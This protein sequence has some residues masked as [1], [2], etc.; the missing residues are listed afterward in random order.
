VNAGRH[1]THAQQSAFDAPYRLCVLWGGNGIGK[2]LTLAELARRHLGME[3]PWQRSGQ[4]PVVVLGGNTWSQLGSTLHYLWDSLPPGWL[5]PGVR[6]ESGGLK[7]QRLQVYDI[8]GGPGA[9][10]ELRC[11]T[12]SAGAQ[13]LA[14][15]RASYVLCDE[16]VKESI[17]NE[18]W[19]RLFGR[20]GRMVQTFTVTMST[21]DDLGYLWALVDDP[22]KPWAG[23]IQT[24]LTLDAVTPRGGVFEY[25]WMSA[26]EI[27]Q[28]EAGLS[29]VEA[30]MRMG[31]TRTPR[32]N[33]AWFSSWGPHLIHPVHPPGGTPLGVG[34]DH[35]SRPGAQRA[36]LVAVGGRGPRARAWILG[37]H[38]GDGRTESE[39]DARGILAML[40]RAGVALADV[41]LWVGDRAHGGDSRGGVKS[42]ARLLRSFALALGIDTD[43]REWTAKLPRNLRN[44]RTPRKYNRSV[45]EGMEVL[46]R[47]TVG[48]D[49][50]LT[51][52]PDPCCAPLNEDFAL[53][54]GGQTDPHK[55]GLDSARYAIV[56]MAE[57][58]TR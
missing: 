20:G 28:A 4:P 42:N 40:D 34:I 18:L 1:W 31:R 29:R 9:G 58:E 53:W 13:N 54:Q 39:E 41:D 30:D 43:A 3:Q 6:F 16:P 44:I 50:R 11:G 51:M 14:G 25:P 35:G 52:S 49:P 57:G 7:G 8:V 15:P 36:T 26:E 5:R 33:T 22:S 27:R 12:W 56:P 46:H 48:D 37:H 32:L 10:G 21:C 55:D 45:W 19:P 17:H 47:M 24:E 38:Q 2:S 23:Q